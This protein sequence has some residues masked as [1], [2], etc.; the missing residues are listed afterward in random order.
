MKKRLSLYLDTSVI[1]GYFDSEFS[2]ATKA[3]FNELSAG[4]MIATIS[5]VVL[6]ELEEAPTRVKQLFYCQKPK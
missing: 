3:L 2:V 6:A 4:Q 5:D 1:G